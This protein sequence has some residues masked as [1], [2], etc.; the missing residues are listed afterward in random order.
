M[1]LLSVIFGC[2][3]Q[4]K[5]ETIITDGKSI[6]VTSSTSGNYKIGLAYLTNEQVKFIQDKLVEAK[7]LIQKY[8]QDPT[9]NDFDSKIIDQVLSNWRNDMSKDKK[10]AK[11]IID[12]FGAAFGQGIVDELNCEWKV[13]TDQYGTDLTVIN[14]KFV[15]NGFPF[16][17]VQKVVT[18]D[19][20]RS[21]DDIKLM[22]KKQIKEAEE[23]GNVDERK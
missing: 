8:H 22:L 14:K 21:L 18:K 12:I 10:S 6:N 1:G 7:I 2:K 9:G 4:S 19:N 13:L 16:S 23:K 17:S 11:E 3:S 20:P 5:K 15:V